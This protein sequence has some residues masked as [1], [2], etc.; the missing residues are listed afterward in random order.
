M[1]MS[2]FFPQDLGIFM[3][4]E[5]GRLREHVM[6]DTFKERVLSGHNKVPAHMYPH[7]V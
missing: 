3:K 7:F 2:Y 6:V 5:M 1:F 4:E